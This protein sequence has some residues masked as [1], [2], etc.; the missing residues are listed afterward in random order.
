[1]RA[2]VRTRYRKSKSLGHA[3]SGP[4]NYPVLTAVRNSPISGNLDVMKYFD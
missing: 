3:L 4:V 1:M 2:P